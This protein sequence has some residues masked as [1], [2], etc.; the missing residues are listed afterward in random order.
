[1]DLNYRPSLSKPINKEDVWYVIKSMMTDYNGKHLIKHHIHSFNEFVDTKIPYIIKQT[2]PLSIFH[3]YEPKENIYKYEIV[4][5]FIN[6]YMNTPKI[7]EN[8]GS[9]K[10]MYPCEARLR[11]LSY[12]SSLYVDIEINIYINPMGDKEKLSSK[13]IKGIN[14]GKIPIMIHSKYCL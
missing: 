5:N 4:I 14:I 9:I 6:S 10:P 2:N 3:E 12:S 8:D 13:I 1:M 7:N 11:N